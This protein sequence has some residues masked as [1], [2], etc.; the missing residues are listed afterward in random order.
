MVPTTATSISV[1]VPEGSDCTAPR[2][3][4]FR[5][6]ETNLI[7]VVLTAANISLPFGM[8]AVISLSPVA[9]VELYSKVPVVVPYF[10]TFAGFW[11]VPTM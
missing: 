8:N 3:S 1:G 10:I 2:T 4:L 9:N 7:G 6:K 11:F 5:V